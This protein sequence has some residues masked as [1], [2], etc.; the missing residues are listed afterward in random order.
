[1]KRKL[2]KSFERY[3]IPHKERNEV[4]EMVTED[5]KTRLDG[6]F[7]YITSEEAKNT[8]ATFRYWAFGEML[9]LGDYNEARG[10]FNKRTATTTASFPELDQQ[11]LSLVLDG[12]EQK[13]GAGN[14]RLVADQE[15]QA[16]FQK[17]LER[18]NFGP[19]YAFALD[20]INSL[21]LPTERLAVTAGEWCKFTQG[22]SVDN[23]TNSLQGFNTKWCIAGVGYASSYLSH[24]DVWVYFSEDVDGQNSIPRAC[25]VDSGEQGITEVRGIISDENSQ[26]HLDSYITPLVEN[27]LQTLPGGEK[28][29]E[30]MADMKQ[31]AAIYLKSV[32]GEVLDR[33]ELIFIYEIEHSIKSSG[34]QQ[35][36]R[37]EE[38]RSQRDPRIDAPILFECD[39]RE[40]AWS[41]EEITDTTKAYI[42]QW[43]PEV[44]K[45]LPAN[46][47]YVYE[48]FPDKPVFLRT[49]ETDRALQTPTDALERLETEEYIVSS[50]AKDILQ[51]VEFSTE[52]KSYD[53]VSFSIADLGFPGGATTSEIFERAGQYDLELCSAE[54]GPLLRL[55]YPDQ[56]RGEYLI[57]GMEPIV[58]RD[59]DPYMF[60]VHHIGDEQWLYAYDG[61][62]GF[63]W[64]S[65]RRFVFARRK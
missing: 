13:F 46:I 40:I 51:K 58:G 36:P 2:V 7:E 21:R 19:L 22:S 52:A 34:Y 61:K 4:V 37:I 56:P 59:G 25:I 33:D 6:W 35:D 27:K 1:L 49:I 64:S 45:L 16:E 12:M 63:E 48:S 44:L 55:Q 65:D 18:E 14:Q 32:K 57:I 20:Y 11:A 53:L 23:L 3:Q 9:K 50:W 15:K 26:Q 38:L 54:V 30:T 31:L 29:Q 62:P 41:K 28:W 8:P 24:S 60:L 5:Q 17:L 43:K 39:P 42:G 47:S 10:K